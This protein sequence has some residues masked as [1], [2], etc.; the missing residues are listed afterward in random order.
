MLL[1]MF[2]LQHTDVT[3]M[4]CRSPIVSYVY[5]KENNSKRPSIQW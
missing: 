1:P 4:P 3:V 5:I 2:K